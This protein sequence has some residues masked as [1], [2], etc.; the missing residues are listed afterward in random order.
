MNGSAKVCY[1]KL[2]VAF[3]SQIHLWQILQSMVL[4][5]KKLNKAAYIFSIDTEAGKVAHANY[6]PPRLRPK[7]ADA[8]AWAAKVT[9]VLDGKVRQGKSCECSSVH[10][11][12]GR[13]VERRRAR[14]EWELRCIE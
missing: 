2:S 1:T 7:G 10:L 3:I 6:I 14:K 11:I 8:R 5:A 12:S 13:L 9:E 4:Q